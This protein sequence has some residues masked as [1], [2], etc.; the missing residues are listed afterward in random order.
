MIT[1]GN[2]ACED[3]KFILNNTNYVI[4]V[5]EML[6]E[7]IYKKQYTNDVNLSIIL[8][9][10]ISHITDKMNTNDALSLIDWVPP[11]MYFM[12]RDNVKRIIKHD[13]NQEELRHY[14]KVLYDLTYFDTLCKVAIE[15]RV[16]GHINY[17]LNYIKNNQ[18]SQNNN[19]SLV[20]INELDK[21]EYILLNKENLFTL[22][23]ILSNIFACKEYCTLDWDDFCNF[24][25]IFE[26][27]LNRYRLCHHLDSELIFEIS[28]CLA[29][30]TTLNTLQVDTIISSNI[31]QFIINWYMKPDLVND[32]TLVF[33]INAFDFG[34]AK[35]TV[36]IL[37]LNF[38]KSL[39]NILKGSTKP[40]IIELC[41]N[42]LNKVFDFVNR[43]TEEMSD[44]N[45]IIN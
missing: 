33:F 13:K 26:G 21:D 43:V 2:L 28:F 27:I 3:L 29:N 32:P 41:L 35:S 12:T 15:C 38:L 37:Q 1:V 16:L 9:W 44:G 6:H 36:R 34:S 42:N 23:K 10:N 24:I 17:L 11:L 31:P 7:G 14:F 8:L 5:K 40:K 4:R 30:M 22:I 20:P 39:M 45:N 19:R 25:P 18:N